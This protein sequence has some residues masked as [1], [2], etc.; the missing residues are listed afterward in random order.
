MYR[1]LN[2]KRGLP[3]KNVF[4]VL[5]AKNIESIQL[6]NLTNR[7]NW[8]LPSSSYT[9]DIV[10]LC[11]ICKI[12]KPKYIFEIGTLTG[13][14]S[15]HFALNSTI[16]AKV[17]TLDL[18]KDKNVKPALKTTIIDD[19]HI[20]SSEKAYQYCFE[21]TE[22]EKQIHLLFGDSATFD[23]FP[24]YNKIDFFFIDGSHSYDYVRSD[25][26]N[27]LKCCHSGSVIAWHDFGRVGVNGVSKWL[28]EFSKEYEIFSAPGS[29]IAFAVVPE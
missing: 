12:I 29:S 13:Y 25:T 14:S 28:R 10:N 16:D 20:N 7:N 22:V 5:H 8:F 9:A 17:Y 26:R 15:F 19:A 11:L 2:S 21:G 4:E 18:P 23:F 1:T 6:G 24:F 27:A 3:Q